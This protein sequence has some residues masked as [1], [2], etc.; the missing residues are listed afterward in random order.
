[1][2]YSLFRDRE[3]F[4]GDELEIPAKARFQPRERTQDTYLSNH[5]LAQSVAEP[6]VSHRLPFAA[7]AHVSSSALSCSLGNGLFVLY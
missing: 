2:L 7:F 5:S 6:I 4:G 3:F 1:M